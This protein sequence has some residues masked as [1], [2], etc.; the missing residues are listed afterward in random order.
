MYAM[1]SPT[2][3]RVYSTK[4]LLHILQVHSKEG[5][6]TWKPVFSCIT[7]KDMLLYKAVPRNEK[8]WINP[9][10]SHPLLATR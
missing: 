8:Q 6:P 3:V 4:F 10:Q 5:N 2:Y 7:E 1:L 9:V